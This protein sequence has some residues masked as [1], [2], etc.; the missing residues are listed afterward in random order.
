MS[1][2]IVQTL[3]GRTIRCILF[4]FGET[5]WTHT[6]QAT[7]HILEQTTNKQAIAILLEHLAHDTLTSTD[8]ILLGKQLR[9]AVDDQ[10][11][12]MRNQAPAYEP[13]PSLVTTE[14]L[15][16][17]GFPKVDHSVSSAIF[18]ALRIHIPPSRLLFDDVLPTLAELQR[19]GFLLGVVTNRNW[20]GKPFMEDIQQ[21]KLL[22]YF[23]PRYVVV[24]AD[25]GIRKPH[26]SI[27]QYALNAINVSPEETAMVGDSL[28]SDIFGAKQLNIFAIWKPK[29]RLRAKAQAVLASQ[30]ITSEDINDDYLLTYARKHDHKGRTPLD[31]IKPDLIIEHVSDLL[32]TFLEAGP[33]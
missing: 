30:G 28:R 9:Q 18:E 11:R 15:L 22:D 8:T 24:S 23:D 32:E 16:Q 31:E 4:D 17:L 5:L 2:K 26:T 27:F 13:D 29:M 10:T 6:D 1:S 25:L 14:A 21:L 33:Q 7:W 3:T 19:R 20:G 12:L